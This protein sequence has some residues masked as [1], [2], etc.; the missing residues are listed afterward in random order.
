LKLQNHFLKYYLNKNDGNPKYPAIQ[1]VP[2]L[3]L[4]YGYINTSQ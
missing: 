2:F 3:I 1:K 4:F